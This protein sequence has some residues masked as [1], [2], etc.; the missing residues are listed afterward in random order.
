MCRE[1]DTMTTKANFSP[2][3]WNL[4][5]RAPMMAGLVLVT[6]S[7]SG[8]FGLLQETFAMGK[9][10]AEAKAKGSN[11]LISALVADLATAEGR[12]ASRPTD[13]AGQSPEQ[14]KTT[15]LEQMRKV[16]A[17]LDQKATPE[18]SQAVKRWL[19]D[20]GKRVAEAATEGGFLGIGGTQVSE[21]EKTA[22]T[23]L[24]RSLGVA[25]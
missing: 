25:A 10:L 12:Q 21:Q 17:L 20:T 9:V 14:L 5:R 23:E 4:M 22:L 6:A 15:A 24:G 8:P 7:P 1:E 18:E 16:G 19:H 11:E 3:E 13:L 2:E